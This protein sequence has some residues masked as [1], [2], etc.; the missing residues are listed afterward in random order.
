[1]ILKF[2]QNHVSVAKMKVKMP[3]KCFIAHACYAS[4]AL[5]NKVYKI[6]KIFLFA[7]QFIA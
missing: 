7:H 1:M 2:H 4:N 5:A 6:K 3:L